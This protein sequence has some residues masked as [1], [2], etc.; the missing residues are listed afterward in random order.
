MDV[1]GIEILVQRNAAFDGHIEALK[2]LHQ[3]GCPLDYSCFSYLRETLDL[4][5]YRT[6]FNLNFGFSFGSK[7]KKKKRFMIGKGISASLQRLHF[8]KFSP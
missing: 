6:D 8:P 2:Y 4:S 5:F 7:N 1:L 3:N